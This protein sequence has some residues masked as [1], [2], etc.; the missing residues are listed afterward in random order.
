M[1][2]SYRH[3]L[4]IPVLNR[5]W[6]SGWESI[7]KGR[8]IMGKWAFIFSLFGF[9][10]K[11][12]KIQDRKYKK[13]AII[14]SLKFLCCFVSVVLLSYKNSVKKLILLL[15]ILFSEQWKELSAR[16]PSGEGPASQRHWY[17]HPETSHSAASP[18]FTWR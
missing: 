8:E 17:C 18:R 9:Y 1:S 13:S 16:K 7:K 6:K 14:F 5:F 15:Y 3:N 10:F 11:E 2:T 4:C 12:L